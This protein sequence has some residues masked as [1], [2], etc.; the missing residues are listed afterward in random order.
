MKSV[1]IVA[2][3]LIDLICRIDG[4]VHFVQLGKGKKGCIPKTGGKELAVGEAMEDPN[5][6]GVIVCQNTNGDALIHYCQRPAS[7]QD[8]PTTGVST[9]HEFPQCCWMCVNY[10]NCGGGGGGA[11]ARDEGGD[12]DG[13]GDAATT[14]GGDA[15]AAPEGGEPAAGAPPEGGE[16]A[17]PPPETRTWQK[18]R[19]KG[20]FK[21]H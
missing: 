8:C 4:L 3:I 20:P 15:S 10:I 17:T 11:E 14:P 16:G 1:H 13:V 21:K 2:L 18:R 19:G 9:I 6:C 12:D 5:T 7:F